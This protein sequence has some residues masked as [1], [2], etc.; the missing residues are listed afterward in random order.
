ML[1]LQVRSGQS[2]REGPS[3]LSLIPPQSGFLGSLITLV[4]LIVLLPMSLESHR[5]GTMSTSFPKYPQVS[6]SAWIT[7]VSEHVSLNNG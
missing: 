6:R 5:V 4:Q 1:L 3:L 2:S 7:G